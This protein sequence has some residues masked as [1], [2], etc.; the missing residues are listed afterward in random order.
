MDTLKAQ[1]F[2]KL[3]GELGKHLTAAEQLPFLPLYGVN[4]LGRKIVGDEFAQQH[5]V[6]T[7][8]GSLL[9]LGGATTIGGKVL[10]KVLPKS[11]L[12]VGSGIGKGLG[13]FGKHIN[14]IDAAASVLHTTQNAI[15]GLTD[16]RGDVGNE[17]R[18]FAN[19][20]TGNTNSVW[21]KR[22]LAFGKLGVDTLGDLA[23][24]AND[25]YGHKI[26]HRIPLGMYGIS[27][28]Y[29][30]VKNVAALNKDFYGT[31]GDYLSNDPRRRQIAKDTWKYWWDGSDVWGKTMFDFS[32]DPNMREKLKAKIDEE[33]YGASKAT[34]VAKMR[35]DMYSN[36]A[37]NDAALYNQW[38]PYLEYRD[39][40]GRDALSKHVQNGKPIGQDIVKALDKYELEQRRAL[41]ARTRSAMGLDSAAYKDELATRNAAKRYLDSNL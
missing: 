22:G 20:W 4:Y 7:G 39:K 12:N 17:Y 38:K 37:K 34:D 8:I 26:G 21:Q 15:D 1:G 14:G 25:Y 40:Y 16:N 31:V 33:R 13:L 30:F 5:P 32:D 27:P 36:Y 28:G 41:N 9:A 24:V 3:P 2:K 11:V 10:P 23:N 18:D 6:G 29:K 35:R 19:A